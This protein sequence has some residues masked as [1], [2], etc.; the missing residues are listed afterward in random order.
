MNVDKTAVEA[1]RLAKTESFPFDRDLFSTYSP[2]YIG[3]TSNVKKTLDLFYG[4]HRVLSV[5]GTGA[6]GYEALLHGASHVD[7]FDI[8]ELQRLY[9][10]YMKTA[11]IVLSYDEFIQFFTSSD[12]W[13]DYENNML[14]DNLLYQKLEP[15]LSD[16]VKKVFGPIFT[17]F[18]SSDI[19]ISKLFR[20]DHNL[21]LD[22]LRNASSLYDRE[23][24]EQIQKILRE[25]P[26]IISCYTVSLSDVPKSF[27]GE[28]DLVL[29]DNILDYYSFIPGLDSVDKID[30]FVKR[31]M[32]SLLHKDGRL[33]V[34]Y[35]YAFD[36]DAFCD[37]LGIEKK[38]NDFDLEDD[39]CT[40]PP[41]FLQSLFSVSSDDVSQKLIAENYMIPLFKDIGGYQYSLFDGVTK[42]DGQ[43]MVLTYCRKP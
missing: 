16:E 1:M 25:N 8:N 15:Y 31:D 36:T 14:L 6:H 7:L 32:N 42:L 3:T 22:F 33:Q 40:L 11:I 4:Y 26:D 9:F 29:F 24:Y 23:S 12:E 28:Y 2:I 38:D 5:C 30:S 19:L 13:D 27:E 43:N 35:G 21:S 20:L 39:D 41:D 10:L 17:S 18:D 34:G 37:A